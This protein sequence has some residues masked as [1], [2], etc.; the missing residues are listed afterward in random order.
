M[1]TVWLSKPGLVNTLEFYT[2]ADAMIRAMTEAQYGNWDEVTV[3]QDDETVFATI[4]AKEMRDAS[5]RERK[6]KELQVSA[7]VLRSV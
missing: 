6:A 2:P 7:G 1:F 3:A 4:K 5:Q